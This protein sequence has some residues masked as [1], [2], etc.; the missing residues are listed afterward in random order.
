MSVLIALSAREYFSYQLT[1][2]IAAL[3][4]GIRLWQ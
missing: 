4:C 1:P 3:T 2:K